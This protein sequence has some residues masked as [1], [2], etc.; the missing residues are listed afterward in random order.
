MAKGRKMVGAR[1]PKLSG[2][3]FVVIRPEAAPATLRVA[4]CPHRYAKR[5][6]LGM[7]AGESPHSGFYY[8]WYG[9]IDT[10]L[11]VPTAG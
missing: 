6:W 7:R 4:R 3:W 11:C 9:S 8:R 5:C 10:A 2:I 1:L